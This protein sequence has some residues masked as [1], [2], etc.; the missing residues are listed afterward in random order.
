MIDLPNLAACTQQLPELID[1]LT[2]RVQRA[3]AERNINKLF[4]KIRF[5]DFR[6]TTVEC[7]GTVLDFALFLQ[8][9]ETGFQRGQ[10]PVRLLGVGVRLSEYETIHQLGLFGSQA[11]R[12]PEMTDE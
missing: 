11:A 10:R 12:L 7:I 9:L 6:Q 1:K 3:K 2:Q 5:S 4:I 8:L